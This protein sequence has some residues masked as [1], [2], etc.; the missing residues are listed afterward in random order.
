MVLL[1]EWEP[2]N[3]A[4]GC[5]EDSRLCPAPSAVYEVPTPRKGVAPKYSLRGP[6]MEIQNRYNS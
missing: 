4:V 1:R 2:W 5:H 3:L 6:K